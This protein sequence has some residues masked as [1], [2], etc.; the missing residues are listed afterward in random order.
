MGFKY[1][2]RSETGGIHKGDGLTECWSTFVVIQKTY[3]KKHKIKK[4]Q[5]GVSDLKYKKTVF[6]GFTYT[7]LVLEN[8]DL[9]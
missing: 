3:L 2:T 5:F 9:H 1:I 6:Y 8:L 7:T 4:L